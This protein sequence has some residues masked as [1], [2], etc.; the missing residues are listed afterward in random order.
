M[1]LWFAGTAV[2]AVWLVFRDPAMDL[3]LVVLGAVLPDLV[4][5]VLVQSAGPLHS[6]VA[7]VTVLV[8]VMLA[9][10]GNRPRRRQ[11]LALPIGMFLHLV[12][13][14]AF[15]RTS[16][17]WWPFSG[18]SL[19]DVPLP[20]VARGWWNVLLE[21]IGA[22]LLAW[23]WRR[24]GLSDPERRRLMWRTGRVDRALVAGPPPT[25]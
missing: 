23:C 8:V 13:D 1:L 12:F 15:T 6:V 4:D 14:G 2:V 5:G 17:F 25:C 10:V 9:T 24:F 16:V 7:P 19:P 11:W 20:S 18:L 21:I 22:L 3:R